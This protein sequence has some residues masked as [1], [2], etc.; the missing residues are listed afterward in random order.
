MMQCISPVDGSV[1]V[2]RP[3]ATDA[4]IT[5][6]LRSA[7]K[8]A[9]DWHQVSVADRATLCTALVDAFCAN[10]EQTA[11]ELAWQMGRPIQYGAGEVRGFR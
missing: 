11:E 7:A 9:T 10:P 5:S 8:A 4:E 2:E 3:Y 1:Y 6:V